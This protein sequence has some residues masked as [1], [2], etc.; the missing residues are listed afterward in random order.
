MLKSKLWVVRLLISAKREVVQPH[1]GT[2]C[3][4]NENALSLTW[5][6]L[7]PYDFMLEQTTWNSFKC[8]FGFSLGNL[9]NWDKRWIMPNLSLNAIS[10]SA[11]FIHKGWSSRV[12]TTNSFR[13]LG[14]FTT[15]GIKF[16]CSGNGFCWWVFGHAQTNTNMIE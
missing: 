15:M 4:E 1:L 6:S 16:G 5:F 7:I 12:N 10:S 3:K 8:L 9:W 13:V 2:I 11:Y 14:W